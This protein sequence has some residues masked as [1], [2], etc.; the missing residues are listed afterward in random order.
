MA[1]KSLSPVERLA[2][3]LEGLIM[4]RLVPKDSPGPVFKW[5]FRVPVICYRIGL[6]LFGSFVLL[7]TTIGR[8][9]GKPRYTAL[10]YR[11]EPGGDVI[12][13][14]GWGGHTDW[15][16]NIQ[17]DPH[18]RVQLG[19]KRYEALAKPLSDAD[20]AAWLTEALRLNP[21]SA[22]IWSRWAGQPVHSDAPE[23]LLRAARSFPSFRLKPLSG[24]DIP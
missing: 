7:L 12:I 17:A 3:G 4:T 14:A 22:R 9:S 8:K 2:V 6:P 1:D 16:R 11:R 23:S 10:E 21:A 5:L 18:V 15:R 13:M 19:R 24:Q 20:V